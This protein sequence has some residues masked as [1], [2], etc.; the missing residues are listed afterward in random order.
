VEFD[1]SV[2]GELSSASCAT[3]SEESSAFSILSEQ[4]T[5]DTACI[6]T[7]IVCLRRKNK[8]INQS[9]NLFAFLPNTI[10]F[11]YIS[12]VGEVTSGNHQAYS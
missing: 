1:T 5:C 8:S 9:I 7:C 10:N 3:S 2:V 11:I 6:A 4:L 12:M